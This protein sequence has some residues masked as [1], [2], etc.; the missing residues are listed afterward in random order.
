MTSESNYKIIS[1]H[2]AKILSAIAECM[3]PPGGPFEKG[4]NN[5]FLM[6]KIDFFLQKFPKQNILFIKFLLWVFEILPLFYKFRP[7]SILPVETRIKIL[8][9][10]DSSRS[11]LLRGS[12]LILKLIIMMFFYEQKEIE[13][14]IGYER[15]CGGAFDDLHK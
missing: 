9:N 13:K 14:I 8:E 1:K 6:E 10:A 2:E 4:A 5:D 11:Y 12:V 3:I 15:A 7:F